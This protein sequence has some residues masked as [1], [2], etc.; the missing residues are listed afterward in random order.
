ML[1][2]KSK[3]AICFTIFNTLLMLGMAIACI[4]PF[5]Y[6][7][8]ASLSDS[9][10]LSAHE[11]L[12]IKPLGLTL[13]AYKAAFS[14]PMIFSG[15][16]NTL[17]VLVSALCLNM[18]LTMITAYALSRKE[19]AIRNAG[20][21]FIT[22]TMFFSG[23]LIPFYL[24]V[25]DLGL[26]NTLLALIL[27]GAINAYN[28]IIMRTSFESVPESLYESARL[29]GATHF[30]VLFK[31]V[32]PL[33]MSTIAVIA[34]YYAVAHWNAWFNAMVFLRDRSLFPLQ[35]I[36]REILLSNDTNSMV[37]NISDADSVAVSETIQYAVM[38]IGT[39]PILMV[40]PFAQR[41]FVKGV[42]VGA[43]K[44]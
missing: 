34:L 40:Y 5:I 38:I 10:Q 35:L 43:V 36:M 4:Y 29:D 33:S 3:G 17:I 7:I 23:G 27:P 11:G 28:L 8:F 19:F 25:K 41:Y 26:D 14:N 44:G 1:H 42:M 39:L 24:T 21:A 13:A 31:I 37:T 2:I 9:A 30:T 16:K 18:F 20:M 22:V 6:S 15:Y 12:L 32:I